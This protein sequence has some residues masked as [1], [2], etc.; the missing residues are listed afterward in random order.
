MVGAATRPGS[1]AEQVRGRRAFPE[2]AS[3]GDVRVRVFYSRIGDP[4]KYTHAPRE[5][6]VYAV[7]SAGNARRRNEVRCCAEQ[8]ASGVPWRWERARHDKA[9]Q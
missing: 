8:E 2:P 9:T 1:P 7:I 5:S 4:D 6:V 3:H